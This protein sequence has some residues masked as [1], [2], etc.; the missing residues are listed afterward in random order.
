MNQDSCSGPSSSKNDND[1]D[2]EGDPHSCNFLENSCEKEA[3]EFK[4]EPRPS[5]KSLHITRALKKHSR[6]LHPHEVLVVEQMD[7]FY[8]PASR[9]RKQGILFYRL[10]P[11]KPSERS[12]PLLEDPQEN[13]YMDVRVPYY[14]ALQ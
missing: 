8:V 2:E 9:E 3:E 14:Y 4:R 12:P 7:I 13:I 6:T 10:E 11:P 5:N 1:L